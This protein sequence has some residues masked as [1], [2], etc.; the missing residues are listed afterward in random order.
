[1]L[2]KKASPECVLDH[3]LDAWLGC[4]E[5]SQVCRSSDV[6]RSFVPDSGLASTECRLRH[7][8]LRKTL[9][10]PFKRP[11][12]SLVVDF[13]SPLFLKDCVAVNSQEVVDAA[14]SQAR[15]EGKFRLRVLTQL[16]SF[17]HCSN[18]VWRL[19]E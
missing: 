17:V 19:L 7:T 15:S 6:P 8:V 18:D 16:N 9:E 5:S 11:L 10:G 14:D 1:M 12:P 13:C 3:C 2:W 4:Y